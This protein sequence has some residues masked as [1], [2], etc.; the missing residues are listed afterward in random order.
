[1]IAF[2]EGT[3]LYI[4]PDYLVLKTGEGIGYR[5]TMPD[6]L[7]KKATVNEP[8]SYHIHTHVREGELTLFGFDSLEE[9]KLFEMLIKTSGI[10][11][12]LG[13]SVLSAL[14][15]S[16]LVKAVQNQNI[17]QLNAIPGIGKKTA[18]KLFLDMADQLKKHPIIGI[19]SEDISSTSRK[20]P[21]SEGNELFSAL[22][23]MGFSDRDGLSILGKV[24]G[25]EDSFEAQIKEALALLTSPR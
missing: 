5:I 2:L 19:K 21:S 11:P 25:K 24:Q 15:P 1:M 23:N 16:Q 17:P 20:I 4:E 18:S 13:V 6:P 10:G 8:E 9:R 3:I 14:R 12:K 22:T 7:L